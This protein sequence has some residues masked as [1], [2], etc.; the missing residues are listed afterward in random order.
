MPRYLSRT[1]LV[2]LVTLSISGWGLALNLGLRVLPAA[3]ATPGEIADAAE[4]Y[5]RTRIALG[6]GDARIEQL[7]PLVTGSIADALG[8]LGTVVPDRRSLVGEPE[9][10]TVWRV[11]E[12]ALVELR[13]LVADAGVNEPSGEVVLMELVEG[14]WRASRS[15]SVAPKDE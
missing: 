12:R 8:D 13:F 2:L 3:G 9:G 5:L 10:E 6:A 14:R 15:W 4:E 1:L 11:G 7:E